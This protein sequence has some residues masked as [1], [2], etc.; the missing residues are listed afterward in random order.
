[1]IDIVQLLIE[2]GADANVAL[3]DLSRTPL[4]YLCYSYEN[5]NLIDIVQLLIKNGAKA[6]AKDIDGFTPLHELC[7]FYKR[8]NLKDN[9]QFFIQ[10]GASVNAIIYETGETPLHLLCRHY[11]IDDTVKEEENLR[12][13]IRLLLD[14]GAS[15]NGKDKSGTTPQDYLIQRKIPINM[16]PMD[17]STL[18]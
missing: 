4:H 10:R 12:S 7:R 1:M 15:M 13:L 3:G 5:D 2:K 14:N 11:K 18:Q 8:D 9:V 6:N 16:L 17:R